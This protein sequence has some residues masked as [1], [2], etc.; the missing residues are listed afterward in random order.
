MLCRNEG[1]TKALTS[2][3]MF[4]CMVCVFVFDLKPLTVNLYVCMYVCMY[5]SM[6]VCMYACVY[7]VINIY[8]YIFTCLAMFM[9]LFLLTNTCEGVFLGCVVFCQFVRFVLGH[10]T[11]AHI[12]GGCLQATGRCISASNPYHHR[13]LSVRGEELHCIR[14]K[15]TNLVR[16]SLAAVRNY[17]T[18]LAGIPS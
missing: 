7:Y 9:C 17:I 14:A 10:S 15:F 6:Y 4:V 11:S 18:V 3:S 16:Q 8:T 5:V 2:M 1:N 12:R 13:L